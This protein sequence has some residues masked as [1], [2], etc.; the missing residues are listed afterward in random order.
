MAQ[1]KIHSGRCGFNTTVEATLIES[2][3]GDRVRLSIQSDC[4]SCQKLGAILTE[5]D[6]YREITYRGGGPLT[7]ELAAKTLPH[8]A[9]PVPA[10]IIKAIEVAS[11]LALP[12]DASIT[13]TP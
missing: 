1:A 5:V 13:I 11:H 2:D 4:K 7:L 6:P 3:D 12:A 10:G 8:T 9:C